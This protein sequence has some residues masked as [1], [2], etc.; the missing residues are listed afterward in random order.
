M[1]ILISRTLLFIVALYLCGCASKPPVNLNPYLISYERHPMLVSFD[2]T[3]IEQI[4]LVPFSDSRPSWELEGNI[5]KAMN[6]G[7][8]GSMNGNFVTNDEIWKEGAKGKATTE[9]ISS[10]ISKALQD[11]RFFKQVDVQDDNMSPSNQGIILK[12][13]VDS[14][15]GE[16]YYEK[17]SVNVV[18]Y[19]KK[20][21]KLYP[22]KG[23]CVLQYELIDA[24]TGVA[25]KSGTIT[26]DTKSK[27]MSISEAAEAA[28]REAATKLVN[29]ITTKALMEY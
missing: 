9:Q 26:S 13:K 11:S 16:R 2:K 23:H 27:S 5:P 7:V 3:Q 8:V 1:K 18:V 6:V 15:Y 29:E 4:Q 10:L 21:K 25:I 22:S 12:G 24:E 28:A 19:S 20:S 17:S 14:F